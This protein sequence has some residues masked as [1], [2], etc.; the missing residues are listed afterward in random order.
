M[1]LIVRVLMVL[2]A[3]ITALFLARDAAS[4]SIVQTMISMILFTVIIAIIAFWPR[5]PPT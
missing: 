2:A 5:R 4:F 1:S 3:P